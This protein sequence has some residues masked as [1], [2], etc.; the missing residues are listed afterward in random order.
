MPVY[1]DK[2]ADSRHKHP[3]QQGV[4]ANQ[5]LW[6]VSAAASLHNTLSLAAASSRVRAA[7]KPQANKNIEV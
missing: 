2:Q 5:N 6:L 7:A 3:N 4:S 1:Q